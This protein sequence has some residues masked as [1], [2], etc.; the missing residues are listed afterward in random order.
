MCRGLKKDIQERDE[1]I[2]EKEKRIYDLKRK[3]QVSLWI[4]EHYNLKYG[5]II[6]MCVAPIENSLH[7]NMI[8]VLTMHP[9]HYKHVIRCEMCASIDEYIDL[10]LPQLSFLFLSIGIGKVQVC[11]GF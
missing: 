6:G 10:H 9:N 11:V 5:D 1:T 3:N 8:P 7:I 2:G 4:L